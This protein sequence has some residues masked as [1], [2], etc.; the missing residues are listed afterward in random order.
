MNPVAL[1]T[2]TYGRDLEICTLLCESVDRHVTSFSR[3]YLLVP[4]CDLPLFA[5]LASERRIIIPASSFLPDWLRPLPRVIQRKRRQFWWSLRA[6]PVNGW[7]VQQILKIAATIT[8]PYERFCILDSDIVF[9]RDFDLARF[10]Y[11]NTIPLLKMAD[12]VTADQPR[13]SRWL[14]TS[15]QLIGLPTP[16]FPAPDFIGHIIFWDKQTTRALAE[17]IEAVSGM[18][19]IEALCRTREFSEYLLYGFFII[20]DE[21]SALRHSVVPKT[22]CVSYWDDPTLSKDELTRLLLRAN[23]DD[24]AFSIASFSGTPVATI[25]EVVAESDAILGSMAATRPAE[26]AASC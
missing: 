15:H 17:R 3:H 1:L 24:V 8:L 2:P 16:P 14:A 10:Q 23:K 21:A 4:D 11:P 7:H 19:W 20:N 5:P 18:S 12:A 25:R 26:L 13:H 6:K 22:Q 9:F